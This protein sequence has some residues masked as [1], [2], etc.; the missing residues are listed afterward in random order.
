MDI[1]KYGPK[2]KMST[3][4]VFSVSDLEEGDIYEI[5][6]LARKLKMKQQVKEKLSVFDG[7]N[8]AIML[9]SSSSRTRIS[10]EL[11]VNRIGGKTLYLSPADADFYNGLTYLDAA[12]I[13][14]AYGVKGLITKDLGADAVQGL[15]KNEL[16]VINL[17]SGRDNACQILAN[18]FT[19]WE[20]AGK[21]S[22]VKYAVFGNTTNVSAEEINTY[23][24]CGMEVTLC[25]PKELLPDGET[26]R[27][28]SQFGD[29]KVTSDPSAA[30]ADADV[31][32]SL[33]EGDGEKLAAYGITPELLDK[34]P[35]AKFLHVLPVRHGEEVADELLYG[36]KSAVFARA[37]NLIYTEQSIMMLY[38][39]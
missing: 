31:V 4:H 35:R 21:L 19:V 38:F 23:V 18:L 10:F 3:K 16:P 8:V 14:R 13:L 1:N 24:K 20:I 15:K 6:H 37:A 39:R 22:G 33:W 32:T 30:V 26:M 17:K 29:V 5:L 12:H 2:G 27:A 34:N 11:A 36:E 25:G 28:L 7:K 9:Q